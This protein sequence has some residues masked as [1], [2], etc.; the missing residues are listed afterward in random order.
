MRRAVAGAVVTVA[1]A[2]LV[3]GLGLLAQVAAPGP[4]PASDPVSASTVGD[5]GTSAPAV[6]TAAP[7]ETVWEVVDRVAPE[8]SGSRR[9]AFAERIVTD[10]RLDTVRLQ[11]GQVLRVPAG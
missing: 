3:V 8:L 1:A 5:G 10:N 7:G 11:P 9:A 2:V 4:I 6:V